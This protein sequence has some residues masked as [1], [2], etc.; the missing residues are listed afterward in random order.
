[1]MLKEKILNIFI[2]LLLFTK[3]IDFQ[4]NQNVS[5]LILFVAEKLESSFLKHLF[6]L[7][8][9]TFLKYLVQKKLNNYSKL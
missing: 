2:A 1:M 3:L 9:T 8:N 5:T 7:L 6:L 4:N